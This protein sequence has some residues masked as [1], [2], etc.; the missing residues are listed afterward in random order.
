[1]DGGKSWEFQH[2]PITVYLAGSCSP[3]VLDSIVIIN[4]N[5]WE[6]PRIQ[7]LDCETGDTLWAIRDTEHKWTSLVYAASP[8]L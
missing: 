7:A 8:V 1:L 6:D 3:V 4:V 2:L 5:G